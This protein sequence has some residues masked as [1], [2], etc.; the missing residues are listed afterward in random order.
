MMGYEP[1]T[2]VEIRDALLTDYANRIPGADVSEGSD[3]HVKACAI[4]SA[5]W[6]LYQYQAWIARQVFPDTADS[7]ELDRHASIRGLSRKQAV[8]SSG[9]VT[10]TGTDG[11]VVSTGLTLTTSEDV[12]FVTTSGGTIAGGVLDAAAEAKEG[13][14]AGNIAANTA[15]T[16]QDPPAGVNSTAS[17]K[18]LFTGGTDKEADPALLSRLLDIIRQP[19]AG[20]NSN[21]YRRWALEAE[22]CASAYV[23]PTRR[24]LGTVDLVILTSG[25]GAARIPAQAVLDAVKANID[26]VRPVTVKDMYVL[27]PTAKTQ[28]VTAAIK[29][30]SGYT[31]SQ[32]KPWVEAAVTAYMN[33]MAPGEILYK[34][35]LERAISDVEGVDDRSVTAPSMNVTPVDNGA[36]VVEMIVPGT[37]TITEMS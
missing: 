36:L 37:V 12:Q 26:A 19:P 1:K 22:G 4:A 28:A 30:S 25:D 31:F 7:E 11:T 2:Y 9:T 20:G 33:A 16:V 34:S 15:L 29:A 8:K 21:D 6:G 27:A 17:A 23:Y 13:G 5:L 32:V 10:L 24:G 14:V 18:V 3:I 35:K